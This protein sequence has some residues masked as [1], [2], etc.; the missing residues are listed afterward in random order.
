MTED[1]PSK[2]ALEY[3]SRVVLD[4]VLSSAVADGTVVGAI[5]M[6]GKADELL[7]QGVF[8]S[9]DREGGIKATIADVYMLASLTKTV[10]AVAAMQ[11][12]EREK[13][14][15]DDPLGSLVP[16]FMDP[17]VLEGFQSDGTPLLRPAR[18]PVT[19][20]RLL[21][22][23]SGLGHEIW[24][25]PLLRYQRTTGLPGLGSRTNASLCIPLLS[26]PGERW[27]YSIGLEWTGKVIEAVTGCTLGSYLQ[28]NIFEP[29]HM[30]DTGFGILP[31]H[32]GRVSTIYR[33]EVD[34]TLQPTDF[35][36]LPGEYEAGGGGLYGTAQDYF[37]FLQM[38]LND[39]RRG[40]VEILKPETA[41][42]MGQNQIGDLAVTVMKTAQPALSNDF[43]PY[44][45]MRKS[46]GLSGMITTE[47]VPGGRSPDS[48]AWGGLANCYFWLDP[49]AKIAGLF[50]TQ[51]LPFGDA[52][53]L[54]LFNEL[55]RHLY[56]GLLGAKP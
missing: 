47:A 18:Y 16:E 43:A 26:D 44:P 21:S 40:D 5:M 6:V 49:T 23:T 30:S 35:T 12:V 17:Q 54:A 48:V 9:R 25:E 20:R 11:L 31:Q 32:G 15:L 8:G 39:G 4:A 52:H 13:L 22:H 55:E 14:G 56:H 7:Y 27:R 29:L 50:L 41:R 53:I 34:G 45:H 36:V 38:L 2:G 37:R 28:N 19:L 24:D 33:R 10:T 1:L 51:V 3:R 46:W 42:L